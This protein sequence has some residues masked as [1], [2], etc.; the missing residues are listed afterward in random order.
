M[1]I[2]NI[3]IPIEPDQVE[4]FKHYADKLLIRYREPLKGSKCFTITVMEPLD[5]YWLG[6]NLATPPFDNGISKHV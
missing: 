5:L 2:E 3:V 4:R 6:C 1:V